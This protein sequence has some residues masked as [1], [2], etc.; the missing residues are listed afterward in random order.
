MIPILNEKFNNNQSVILIDE[1]DGQILKIMYP[2]KALTKEE[3]LNRMEETIEINRYFYT[4]LKS[5]QVNDVRNIVIS[6]HTIFSKNSMFSGIYI[7]ILFYY[8][9]NI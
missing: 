8:N 2:I 9:I 3:Q 6:G 5:L 7:I 4:A 1:Y